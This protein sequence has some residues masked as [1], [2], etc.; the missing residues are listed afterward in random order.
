MIILLLDNVNK[1]DK[2]EDAKDIDTSGNSKMFESCE[3]CPS[4]KIVAGIFH[5]T[6]E[7]IA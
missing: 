3:R 6:S 2:E 7:R 5:P 1:S 4:E